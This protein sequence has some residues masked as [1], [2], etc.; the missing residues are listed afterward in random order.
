[1][2]PDAPSLP[3]LRALHQRVFA[4]PEVRAT[5]DVAFKELAEA[6]R[7]RIEPPHATC[8]IPIELFTRG[9]ATALADEVRLCRAFL[10]RRGGRMAVPEVHRNS[11]QRLVSYRGW[12]RIHAEGAGEGSRRGPR[13]LVAR[14]IHSP[15][16][17]SPR[18]IPIERCWDIVP[19]G[20]WHLP[21]AGAGADW[22]TV[23]FHSAPEDEIV[24]E[25][26]ESK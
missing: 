23:T 21:E 1:M 26:W 4:V 6:L 24:D 19:A 5:L 13:N 2:R 14:T 10:L 15:D 20:V 16:R 25:Y 8:A 7:E 9:L 11:V 3:L 12:G 17:G 22:A 18:T